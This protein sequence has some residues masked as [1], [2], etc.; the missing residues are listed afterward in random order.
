MGDIVTQMNTWYP[1]ERAESWDRVGLILGNTEHVAS[2]VLLALDPV[3]DTVEEA[4]DENVDMMIVHHPLYLRG[5][6]FLPESDPKGALVTALIRARIA[7]FSAHTNADC[8]A[9]GTGDALA[10][11]VGIRNALPL[12]PSGH[13]EDGRPYGHGRIGE[14]TPMR[15]GDFADLVA[16]TLP[17]GPTGLMCSG[18][19]DT[20]VTRVAVCPGAGDSF[21]D[22]SRAAG[23]EVLLTADLRHH[24]A[25]EHRAG[26]APALLCA[27][28]W[29]TESVW[30]P[31]LAKRLRASAEAANVEL[32]VKVSTIATEP[33]MSH[34]PTLGGLL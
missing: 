22:A 34:R 3:A 20:W 8:S 33:W 27:S 7:L 1:P 26:G 16:S 4:V 9:G 2:R 13:G 30:L 11:R 29:A 15:L 32:D 12:V 14:I 17:A 28:H 25:L 21:L 10:E 31:P 5:T 6:S 18:D 23:A 19:E 24:P